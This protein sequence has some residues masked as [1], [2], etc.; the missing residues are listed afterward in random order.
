M[1]QSFFNPTQVTQDKILEI[2][3]IY[4]SLIALII[5][6]FPQNKVTAIQF[7][8]GGNCQVSD[9]QT[10]AAMGGDRFRKLKWIVDSL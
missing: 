4:T 8:A 1:F 3:G 7:K 6:F 2:C 5:I 9:L 10:C